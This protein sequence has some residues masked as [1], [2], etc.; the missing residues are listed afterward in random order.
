[1]A[2]SP[3]SLLLLR[4]AILF[5]LFSCFLAFLWAPL[6]TKLHYKYKLLRNPE[7]D[8]T[9]AMGARQS[10]AGVPIMGGLLVI[11]TVAVVTICFNWERK[12]T[13]VPI[14]VMI[15]AALL[16]GIDDILNIYGSASAGYGPCL[17]VLST[18]DNQKTVV[19]LRQAVR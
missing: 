8:A 12:F 13:W 18:S 19:T 9:L 1:M 3:D 16:G 5:S 2:I 11:I 15:L 14:G 7:Y 6:L 10:K 4:E 17:I